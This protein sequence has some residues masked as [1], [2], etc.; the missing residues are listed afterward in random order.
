M[1]LSEELIE[2]KSRKPPGKP[3]TP[4]RTLEETNQIRIACL[5]RK[6]PNR[7]LADLFGVSYQSISNWWAMGIPETY[8][9]GFQELMNKI[10]AWEQRSG[11][12][13]PG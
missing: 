9:E 7:R 13:F 5:T 4:R 6:I 2:L 11:K 10:T 3:R 12:T 1:D 8:M